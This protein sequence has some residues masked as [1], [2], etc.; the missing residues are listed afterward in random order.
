MYNKENIVKY[1][2]IM[3]Q[4]YR[5]NCV[6]STTYSKKHIVEYDIIF[7]SIG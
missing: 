3:K 6:K 4:R 2:L 5:D 1:I 7:I